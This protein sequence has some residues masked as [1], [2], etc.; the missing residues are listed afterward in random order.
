MK[1]IQK[2]KEQKQEEFAFKYFKKSFKDL[3]DRQSRFCSYVAEARSY[4]ET[5]IPFD[6]QKFT[7]FDFD[8]YSTDKSKRLISPSIALEAKNI[9]CDYCWGKTWTELKVKYKTDDNIKSFFRNN[10]LMTDRL[11]DGNNLVILG[12][13]SE[14]K[15]GRTMVASI[16]MSQSIKLRMRTGKKGQTYDWID[17]AILKDGLIKNLDETADWKNCDWL[18]IDNIDCSLNA[19]N[20]QTAFLSEITIPFFMSRINN[21]LPTILVF[22]Y[23]FRL[24]SYNI[25]S[26]LG[27]GIARIVNDKKTYKIPLS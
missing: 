6:Y 3:E 9:I 10:S 2:L 7:I 24:A 26:D 27:S 25:N 11:N 19:S 20:K 4:V 17:F 18:V 21:K 13:A 5:V 8:G 16:I 1:N 15:I 22:Q 14:E 23:D 12:D